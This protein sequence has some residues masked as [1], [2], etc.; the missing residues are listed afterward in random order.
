M[1][2]TASLPPLI[3]G[4]SIFTSKLQADDAVARVSIMTYN[5]L[6]QCYV[7]SSFFPYCDPKALR[8]KARSA[9]LKSQFEAFHPRADIVCLQECD[10]YD[11]FWKSL[12]ESLGYQ[13][14]YLKKTGAKKDGVG[15]FWQS[16]KFTV[17]G[18]E[19]VSLNNAV[20][21][22]TDH[23]LQGRLIRDNVGL[24]AH[25]QSIGAGPAVEFL[26]ATTHLFWDPAQADVKLAQTTH[27]LASIAAFRESTHLPLFFAGDF[28]SLPHSH[29]Y[30]AILATGLA[31]AYAEYANGR[32]PAF[33]NVNGVLADQ[34]DD[35][36]KPKP[37]FVGTL[38]YIFYDPKT[39]RVEALMPLMDYATATAEGGA[40][41]SRLVGSDHIPLMASFAFIS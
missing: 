11:E 18:G 10:Q 33:T 25:F 26:V 30:D 41:P 35:V 23:D 19:N 22:V 27:L 32:E 37:A 24:I 39:T 13:S 17:L 20:H 5:V 3:P 1:S 8:W 31:S 2:G 29:V 12:M 36:G 6:A 7:K 28:N 16:S 34:V 40:L 15:L 4:E 14:L 38:D 9:K 21:T